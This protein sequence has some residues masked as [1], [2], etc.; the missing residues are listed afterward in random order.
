MITAMADEARKIGAHLVVLHMPY[1]VRGRVTEP[2]P[3]LTAAIAGLDLTFVDVTPAVLAFHARDPDGT[4]TLGDDPHPNPVAHRL[5]A[6]TIA[7]PIRAL[8]ATPRQ[9][10]A[11]AAKE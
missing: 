11:S 10:S 8:L 2:P 7:E 4:L 5:I 1:L 3:A 9:G 6:E